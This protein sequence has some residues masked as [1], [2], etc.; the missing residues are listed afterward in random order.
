MTVPHSTIERAVEALR[1]GGLVAFPTETVYGLGADAAN[2][3]AVRRIFAVKGR[4][5]GHP[6][7]VHLARSAQ[8]HEWACLD[9]GQARMV[10]TLAG[11]FWPGPLTVV[12]PRSSRVASETVGGGETIGLRVPD[13][14]IAFELLDRFGGG[15]AAPSANRFGRVSPTTADHVRHDFGQ[16]V[17]VIID[18]GP[19]EVGV[20]STIIELTSDRPL[21]LRPGG[22]SRTELSAALGVDV[23]DGRAGQA[24]AAGMLPSHYAP[25]ATVEVLGSA[26]L[27]ARLGEIDANGQASSIGVIAPVPVDRD[28]TWCLPADPD[29]Y[30]RGIYASLRAADEEGVEHLL[31]VPPDADL[32]S[33]DLDSGDMGDAILDRLAKAAAPRPGT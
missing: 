18:G 2:P 32:D 3:D 5:V 31:V 12:V 29:G 14:P 30:A 4:P 10:D 22:I 23:V 6:L 1:G 16:D 19:T 21:L 7:I 24:R 17:D 25:R 28:R 13:H 33:D 8:V 15:V 26:E 27:V 11:S 20:E 9:D